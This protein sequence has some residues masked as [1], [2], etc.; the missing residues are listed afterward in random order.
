KRERHADDQADLERHAVWREDGHRVRPERH[1]GGMAERDLPG[2]P[3]GEVQSDG[4]D[5]VHER[6]AQ[7]VE[8]VLLEAE[9][10]ERADPHPG[11]EA[12][13]RPHADS[14]FSP[15]RSSGFSRRTAMRITSANASRK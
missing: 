14:S 4:Q 8:L 5:Q 15:Q 12:A 9:W 3:E 11:G 6:E 10:S 2:V 13:T 1:E 7:D